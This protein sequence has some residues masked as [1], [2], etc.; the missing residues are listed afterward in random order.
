MHQNISLW[1]PDTNN[2][3]FPDAKNDTGLSDIAEH[4]MAGILKHALALT[5]MLCPSINS[6]RR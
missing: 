2:N 1:S 6:Y 4:F 5:A 3:L